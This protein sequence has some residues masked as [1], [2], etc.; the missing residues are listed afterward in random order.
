MRVSAGVLSASMCASP[1]EGGGKGRGREGERPCTP[2]EEAVLAALHTNGYPMFGGAS[3]LPEATDPR[4]SFTNGGTVPSPSLGRLVVDC[5]LP[6]VLCGVALAVEATRG[7]RRPRGLRPG[8]A[9][10]PRPRPRPPPPAFPRPLPRPSPP[11]LS[12]SPRSCRPLQAGQ[13]CIPICPEPKHRD[14]N[15]C[16]SPFLH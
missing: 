10:A 4:P 1:Q 11:P 15:I 5:R 12:L 8:R 6:H 14:G 13:A 16:T 9:R 7:R 2:E 3:G